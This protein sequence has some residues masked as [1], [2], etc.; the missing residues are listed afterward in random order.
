M[1]APRSFR[2]RAV[3]TYRRIHVRAPDEGS[4]YAA[5]LVPAT[6]THTQRHLGTIAG[7]HALGLP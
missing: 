3:Y 5:N 7:A 6:K 4:G 2:R 1:A